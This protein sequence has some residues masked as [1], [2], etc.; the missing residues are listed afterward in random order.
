MTKNGDNA[1]TIAH[2]KYSFWFK[3]QNCLKHAEHVS[4][5]TLQLFHKK[6]SGKKTQYS[7]NEKKIEAEVDST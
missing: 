7:K 5:N 4:T 3:K 1:K 6:R 2:A